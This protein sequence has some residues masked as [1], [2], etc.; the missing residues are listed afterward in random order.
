MSSH[1]PKRTGGGGG[2]GDR[3]P[4]NLE[5]SNVPK[6]V[7]GDLRYDACYHG[8]DTVPDRCRGEGALQPLLRKPCSIAV[9][10]RMGGTGR[11]GEGVIAGDVGD[12]FHVCLATYM[13]SMH[14]DGANQ[15]PRLLNSRSC[16]V[17]HPACVYQGINQSIISYLFTKPTVFNRD[18][19]S[20]VPVHLV[21]QW[22]N[23]LTLSAMETR[24]TKVGG[25]G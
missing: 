2:R 3:S 11:I 5:R 6:P 18:V 21:K 25:W 23:L 22:F 7:R 20:S 17:A 1:V 10:K 4:P 19:K 9:S 13:F 15:L 24:V 8:H 14:I 12:S 16:N